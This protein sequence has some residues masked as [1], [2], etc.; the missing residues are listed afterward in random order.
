MKAISWNGDYLVALD[1]T[2]LPFSEHLIYLREADDYIKA[3]RE[4]RVRGAPL[5]GIVAGYAIAQTAINNSNLGFT[6]FENKLR[7]TAQRLVEARPTAVN[8]KWAVER[9]LRVLDDNILIGVDRIVKLM[10]EE[11]KRIHQEELNAEMKIA[12]LG[13]SLI[14]ARSE[15]I[16]ICNTGELATGGIGTGLGV[17][18]EAFKQNKVTKVWVLETRPYIQGRLTAWELAKDRIPFRCVVDGAIGAVLERVKIDCAIV[19]ADRIAENGDFANKIGTYPL[20]VLCHRH[21]VKFIVCAPRSSYDSSCKSGDDIKIEERSGD[22]VRKFGRSF[23]LPKNYPVWNPSFD[24]T[25]AE[26]VSYY[27]SE[28]GIKA[29]NRAQAEVADK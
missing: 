3:I 7:K 29:G 8:L 15:I 23:V 25:P 9:M 12:V 4:M 1:Q 24:L 2:K 16:T 22:E 17:V 28:D 6:A 14:S 5:I 13:A 10:V 19:G 18:R 26:L 11:A 27:V 20:A 21:R